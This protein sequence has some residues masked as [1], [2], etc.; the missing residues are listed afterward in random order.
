MR[1]A[2]SILFKS[3]TPIKLRFK[4][5][6]I[7]LHTGAIHKIYSN[8]SGCSR[9]DPNSQDP[10]FSYHLS[11]TP[12]Q[13]KSSRNGYIAIIDVGCCSPMQSASCHCWSNTKFT[14][15]STRSNQDKD[16]RGSFY[17]L[18]MNWHSSMG[19]K[20]KSIGVVKNSIGVKLKSISLQGSEK[21]TWVQ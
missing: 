14:C 13:R 7:L 6:Q 5:H 17:F 9:S 2:I 21:K 8:P 1:Y 11:R 4:N 20:L 10:K 3:Q 12:N 16:P 19:V 18:A 15:S